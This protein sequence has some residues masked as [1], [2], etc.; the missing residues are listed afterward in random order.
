MLVALVWWFSGRGEATVEDDTAT[1]ADATDAPTR[2][3]QRGS[4]KLELKAPLAVLAWQRPTASISGTVKDSAGRP[5]SGAQVCVWTQHQDAPS[6]MTRDPRCE[7]TGTDGYYAI[8]DLP[9]VHLELS[10][11]APQHVPQVYKVDGLATLRVRPGEVKTDVDFV[12]DAG[13]VEVSGVVKDLAGG[14]VEGAFVTVSSGRGFG[15]SVA[16]MVIVSD[17]EGLFTG[18][19]EEGSV[20]VRARAD[21]YGDSSRS[22]SA[23]GYFFE[24]FVTPESVVT[25]RVVLAGT[26]TPV[27]NA[28]VNASTSRWGRGMKTVTDAEGR[29]RIDRLEPGTYHPSATADAGYGQAEAAVH[30]GL[31]QSASDVLIELHPAA[32]VTGVVTIAGSDGKP[33]E[34]G[35]VS[36]TGKDGSSES[37]WGRTELDGSVK[38]RGVLPASYD[39]S[40]SCKDYLKRDDF[41]ALV[42]G[43]DPIPAQQWEVESG[44]VATGIVVDSNGDPIEGA[45]VWASSVLKG[46][47][48]S[49]SWASDDTSAAGTFELKGLQTGTFKLNASKDGYIEPT[50][51]VQIEVAGADAEGTEITLPAGGTVRGRVVGLDGE[52]VAGVTVRTQG[53]GWRARATTD[54]EGGFTLEGADPGEHRVYA[55]K[56]WRKSLRAPGATDDDLRGEMVTVVAGEVTEVE[57]VV[58]SQSG[59]VGGQVTADG[60]EPVSDAFI[61]CTRESDSAGSAAGGDRSRARWGSSGARPILTDDDGRFTVGE[62]SDGKYTI[63][64]FRKG[65]GEA[66]AEHIEVGTTDVELEIETTGSMSGVVSVKGGS[67]P[68]RFKV[69]AVD[70]KLGIRESDSFYKTQGAW[71]LTE[72]A[73]GD[74]EVTVTSD[75]G[76]AEATV[77]LAAGEEADGIELELTPRL[78][79]SGRVLDLETDEPVP[80][81]RVSINARGGGFNITMSG[82]GDQEN[83]SDD[84]G[85]FTLPNATAGRVTIMLMPRDWGNDDYGWSSVPAD[86]PADATAHTL[87]DIHIVKSRKKR[88][89]DGSD[90]GF[91]IKDTPPGAEAAETPISVAFVRP[92]GPAQK[93]GL[94]VG[95]VI[96]AVDGHD[97]TGAKRYLYSTLSRV[98]V[99]TSLKLKLGERTV[100]VVAAK[101]P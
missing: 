23:P 59:E 49:Q 22:G 68:A 91:K 64:A 34:S 98:K 70:K 94:K 19:T 65:G 12:L 93:A 53:G 2:A 11:S 20:R 37:R 60:G 58:E 26:K 1:A 32:V 80:G 55:S 83:V 100:T 8:R 5:I 82:K 15:S 9:P 57:L 47:S 6:A 77:S 30:V 67:P 84:A 17:A 33:C 36:L 54:D 18:W 46:R 35:S 74:F 88:E 56:G 79:V 3:A 13:G 7:K 72:L 25:G 21:G 31:A 66:V 14:V 45:N 29:F 39:V 85:N 28:V 73:A 89:D 90:L 51:E 24:L 40:V 48:G 42:V 38:I 4:A 69:T 75:A 76:D 61:S 43:T 10:A 62:L 96:E 92:G 95:D 101:E 63:R 44:F 27:A 86:I 87:P 16:R 99:G 52:P 81:I 97:V 41:D 71:S 78:E 50:D